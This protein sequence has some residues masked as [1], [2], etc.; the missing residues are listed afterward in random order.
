MEC[1]Q[2]MDHE[3]MFWYR[4]DPGLGLQLLYWSY[5]INDI[6]Q[7]DLP[8]GYDVS[9]KKKEAFL[10]TLESASTN[11]TSV[12]LCAS[13][14]STARLSQLLSAQKAQPR[15]WKILLPEALPHNGGGGGLPLLRLSPDFLAMGSQARG[16]GGLKQ[17]DPPCERCSII[18][19]GGVQAGAKST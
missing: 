3:G 19:R 17:G 2:N 5:G 18:G 7:G 14:E 11:Q 15:A 8:F 9:R 12:Y 1:S 16:C 4:Q 6:E 10:L 13:S